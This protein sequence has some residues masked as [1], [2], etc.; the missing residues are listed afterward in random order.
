VTQASV[1]A[2]SSNNGWKSDLAQPGLW[3]R[4]VLP[5]VVTTYIVDGGVTALET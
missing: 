3:L 4:I 2:V 1:S 5:G